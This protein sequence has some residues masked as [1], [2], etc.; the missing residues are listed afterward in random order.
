MTTGFRGPVRYVND[1]HVLDGAPLALVDALSLIAQETEWPR[2][3]GYSDDFLEYTGPNT[4][5]EAGGWLLTEVAVGAG[6]TNR[7]DI[8]DNAPGGILLLKTDNAASDDETLQRRGEPWKYVSGKR[9]V[10]LIR[11]KVDLVA[12]AALFFGLALT[13]TTPIAS[14]PADGL[15]F[16]KAAAAT[17][18]DFHARKGGTSTERTNVDPTAMAND[19][20]REYAF[21]A[22]E[23]GNIRVFVDGTEVAAAA[24]ADGNANIPNTLALALLIAVQTNAATARELR[25]DTLLVAQER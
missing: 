22:D 6:N 25:I 17:K 7:V 1:R 18:M 21:A 9:L 3:Y 11:L 16:E 23:S 14:L 12:N 24:I 2:W 20:Y 5:G 10:F 8:D 13:D 4:A 19:T 15:F